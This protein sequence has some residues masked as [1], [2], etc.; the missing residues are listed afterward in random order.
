MGKQSRSS[1]MKNNH[2]ITQSADSFF[3][4]IRR[5]RDFENGERSEWEKLERGREDIRIINDEDGYT[6]VIEN[7]ASNWDVMTSERVRPNALRHARQL[8]RYIEAELHL[9]NVIPAVVYP[10][11]PQMPGR[12]EEIEEILNEHFIQVVWRK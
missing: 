10:I 1:Y 2:K 11:V 4:S 3:H 5:G 12:K 6:V 9:R 8:W 7:K